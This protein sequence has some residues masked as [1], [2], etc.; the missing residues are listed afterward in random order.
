[1]E[2][3]RRHF[4]SDE[5]LAE[6]GSAEAGTSG[7]RWIIDPLDGTVNFVHGVPQVAVSIG[8]HDEEGPK[9]AVIRDVFRDEEFLATRNHGATL[10]GQPMSIS[11]TATVGNALVSTGFSYDRQERAEEYTRV[12]TAVLREVRGLRRNGSAAL[13]LAWV[14][15]GRFD[16]HWEVRLAPWDVAAGFLLITEAGG[17]VTSFDGGVADHHEFIA[18]NG[19]IHDHLRQ[20]LANA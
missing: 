17:V 19:H 20:L 3:L 9:L 4:P 8:L 13:D 5:I 2:A 10:N 18:S 14:A 1:M 12:V 16:A 15:C 6:E 11:N 7:R